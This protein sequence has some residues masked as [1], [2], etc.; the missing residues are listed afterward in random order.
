MS[1]EASATTGEIWAKLEGRIVNGVFPLRRYLGGSDHSGVFLTE[2]AKRGLSEVALKLIPTTAIIADSYLA[3]WRM[4]G[5]VIHPRLLRLLEA[6]RCQLD[7]LHYL[8]LVMEYSDQNLAQLLERRALAQDEAR[9]MLQPLL[10][11]LAFLHDRNFVQG[12]LTPSNILVVGDQLKLASDTIRPVGDL[13]ERIGAMSAH[14]PPEAR[15][16]AYSQAGDI[17]AL[18]VSLC[19]ALT[20]QLPSGLHDGADGIALSPDVPEAFRELIARCVSRRPSDRPTVANIEAWARGGGLPPAPVPAEETAAMAMPAPANAHEI[21]VQAFEPILA[22]PEQA[23]SPVPTPNEAAALPKAPVTR[24]VI[25]TVQPPETPAPA[26]TQTSPQPPWMSRTNLLIVGALV[27]FALS[28]AALRALRSNPVPTAPTAA[29]PS[30]PVP[31]L[32]SAPSEGPA[33]A[34]REEPRPPPAASAARSRSA[35]TEVALAASQ[36]HEVIPDVPRSARQTI[37]GHIRVSVRVIIDKDGSV[38]AALTERAGPSRYF[39]RLALDAAKKWTFAP[40]S[41][42]DAQRLMLLRFDFTRQGATASASALQ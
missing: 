36:I 2:F 3:R 29:A 13:S 8:Y 9:E 12:R 26:R 39:E 28:W 18:G 15:D 20:R 22:A 17:W 31:A 1:V 34:A 25:P 7:G 19:E 27:V 24:R 23:A 32:T 11:T 33:P 4:A 16:G 6:G 38:F 42:S 37:R 21:T 35:N 40:V 41:D 10:E 14:E 5:G 30:T